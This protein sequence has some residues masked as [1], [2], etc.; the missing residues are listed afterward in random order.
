MPGPFAVDI[1]RYQQMDVGVRLEGEGERCKTRSRRSRFRAP[2]RALG[3]KP[4]PAFRPGRLCPI[5]GWCSARSMKRVVFSQVYEADER[6][7]GRDRAPVC[8]RGERA[9]VVVI[10]CPFYSLGCRLDYRRLSDTVSRGCTNRGADR[11]FADSLLEGTGF[12]PSVPLGEPGRRR[13]SVLVR[14]LFRWRRIKQGRQ[15]PLSKSRSY[16]AVPMVRIRL[17]PAESHVSRPET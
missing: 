7:G 10:C 4:P 1:G 12:E 16:H 14:R 3:S 2:R 8:G 9:E 13:V 6:E 5:R 17:P 15:E 11:A